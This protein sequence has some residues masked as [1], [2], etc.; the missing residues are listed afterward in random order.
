M[1]V[2][3]DNK[4]EIRFHSIGGQGAYTTGQMIAS[5]GSQVKGI[6]SAVFADYG[7][8]KKGSPVNVYVKFFEQEEA[9]TNFSAVRNPNLVVVLHE[10]LLLT[11]DVE[12][13]ITDDGVLV[14]NT[15]LTP[16]ELK[17]QYNLNVKNIATL[18][19]TAI[20]VEY[21]TKINTIVYGAALKITD[22]LDSKAAASEIESKLSYKYPQ[23]VEPNIKSF[24]AGYDQ[25]VVEVLAGTRDD[26][27]EVSKVEYL[28]Y[29]NQIAGGIILGGNSMFNNKS[30]SREGLVPVFDKAKCINCVKCEST[31]PDDC[32]S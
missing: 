19:A 10:Q 32:F 4:Y 15:S 30:I 21:K 11:I 24:Q 12:K 20:G 2:L 17:K 8:E 27:K 14:V 7:S 16:A 31:C 13:G 26:S 3:K 22:F 5:L 29:E 1:K 18:D 6:K 9:I 25:T 23:L 28:G